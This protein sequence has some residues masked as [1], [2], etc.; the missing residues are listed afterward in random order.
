MV[1]PVPQQLKIYHILHIDK[2]PAVI[3]SKAL[4]SDSLISNSAGTTIG[5]SK[6]KERR[7][8][9]SSLTSHPGL[10]VGECGPFYFCPRSVMLYMFYKDNNSEIEYHAGQEPIIHIEAGMVLLRSSY[11]DRI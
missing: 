11:Y 8:T 1:F 9:E 6:I 3:S 5:M 2:L 7:L 10:H 4:F